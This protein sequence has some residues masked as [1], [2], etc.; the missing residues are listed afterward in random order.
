MLLTQNPA[1]ESALTMPSDRVPTWQESFVPNT[2]DLNTAMLWRKC[3]SR[4]E[5]EPISNHRLILFSPNLHIWVLKQI[6]HL[7]FNRFSSCSHLF[8]ESF[9]ITAV[10]AWVC[11]RD[12][13]IFK[14]EFRSK[15]LT[16]L[17]RSSSLSCS[18]RKAME[19][20]WGSSV[21]VYEAVSRTC[22]SSSATLGQ[23]SNLVASV[24]RVARSLCCRGFMFLLTLYNIFLPDF[25]KVLLFLNCK[26]KKITVQNV[27][28]WKDVC[29]SQLKQKTAQC[30]Q[31]LPH[32]LSVFPDLSQEHY[33]GIAVSS[34]K[35]IV[36][37]EM[38]MSKPNSPL[39]CRGSL[40]PSAPHFWTGGGLTWAWLCSRDSWLCSQKRW[41]CTRNPGL[42]TH[43]PWLCSHNPGLCSFVRLISL[44]QMKNCI[45]IMKAWRTGGVFTA[46]MLPLLFWVPRA[47]GRRL[48]RLKRGRMKARGSSH[49]KTARTVLYLKKVPSF[50]TV[51]KVWKCNVSSCLGTCLF[52]QTQRVRVL[53]RKSDT[54]SWGAC[55]GLHIQTRRGIKQYGVFSGCFSFQ[56]EGRKQNILTKPPSK[57]IIKALS[58]KAR[59]TA[60]DQENKAFCIIACCHHFARCCPCMLITCLHA[61]HH[62]T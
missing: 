59:V 38:Q 45:S 44:G 62:L 13:Q 54:V 25:S 53:Q 36:G 42:C 43:H 47:K 2:Q 30:I 4:P 41:P 20:Y 37:I 27:L 48:F 12:K 46:P 7:A 29:F 5:L 34:R 32:P 51:S 6:S 16:W 49:C 17:W 22:V 58:S 55:R 10:C 24:F 21:W 33:Y 19:L 18:L 60:H 39:R 52:Y 3:K 40:S 50:Q 26:C 14:S 23:C 1:S 11:S 8:S 28:S 9:K 15:C 56:Y 61:L 35:S 57:E 31:K